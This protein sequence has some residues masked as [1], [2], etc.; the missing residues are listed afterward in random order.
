MNS[1][2][3]GHLTWAGW[4]RHSWRFGHAE[5][6]CE[7]G[8]E[9]PERGSKMSMVLVV[10]SNFWN[11]FDA[12]QMISCRARLVTMDETWLYRYEPATQQQSMEWQHSGSPHPK[13]FQVQKSAGKFSPRFFGMKTASSSLIIFQRAKLSTRSTTHLCWCKWRTF[14][15]KNAAGRSPRGSCSC[16][17]MPR[18]T[19]H[20]QPRRNWPNWASSV[21]ITHPILQIWPSQNT[22]CSLVWKNKWESP[23]F[24]N[25]EVIAAAQT[26]LDRQHSAFFLEWLAKVRA[27]AKKCIE[28]CG[29][30]VE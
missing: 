20:L 19:G 7:V 18:F 29:E 16:T 22:T 5:P 24:V 6:L 8:P 2:T 1:W 10:P 23:F 3:T 9:M 21:L 4:V 30:Y 26:C 13:K 12:V 14:W 28:L 15:R 17:T 25:A 11:F 27:W